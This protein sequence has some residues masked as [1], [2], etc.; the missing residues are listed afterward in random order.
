MA[1]SDLGYW[2]VVAV[3]AA[4]LAALMS[5]ADSALLSISSMFTRDIYLPYFRPESSESHLTWVGKVFSWVMVASLVYVAIVTDKTL[6]RLLEL[7]FEVLIQVVPS[8]FFGLYW[9]R[10]QSRTVIFGLVTGLIVALVLWWQGLNTVWGFHAGVI[11]LFVNFSI[12]VFV[13]MCSSTNPA[14]VGEIDRA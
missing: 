2:L 9:K 4:A 13:T 6:V 12:C 10:L 7:K 1:E 5:T 8:F 11:G 14:K 3:F